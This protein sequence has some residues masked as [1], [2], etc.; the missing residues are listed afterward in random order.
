ML[1]CL[2]TLLASAMSQAGQHALLIGVSDYTDSRIPDLEGPVNDVLALRDVLLKNWQFEDTDITVLL[3]AQAT[4]AAILNAIDALKHTTDKGDDI[5]IYYSGHGTSAADPDLGARLNLPD[6]SGVIVGSDFDPGKLDRMS[7]RQPADDGLLVGRFEIRPRLQALDTNRNVLVI[8]DACFSGNATREV[9]SI[10]KPTRK[11]QIDL[12]DYFQVSSETANSTSRDKINTPQKS[13]SITIDPAV[14]FVYQ[15]TVYFGAA[16]EDQFAVDLSK[17]EID[18]GLVTT[19]DGKPHGGFTDSLLR[20]LSTLPDSSNSLS[21]IQLFNRTLNL[22]NTWCKACGHT[23]VSLPTASTPDNEL[24][25]RTILI[26]SLLLANDT[27]YDSSSE[28]AL[29]E[30]LIIETTLGDGT[31]LALRSLNSKAKNTVA[32]ATTPDVYFTPIKQQI[33][34]YS[35]D[36]QLITQLPI[37]TDEAAMARW[38]AGRQWLKRRMLQDLAKGAGDLQ[39]SFRH[40]LSSNRLGAGE[41]IHF[42]VLSET[43]ASLVAFVL[44]ANSELSLLYPV[45]DT[46]RGTLLP[47]FQ[48]QRIPKQDEP[49]IQVTPPWGTDTV[50]F[51]TL[52]TTHSLENPLR[53]LALL[54]TIP[55]SHRALKAF[56]KALNTTDIRYS[57]ST[58]RI[59]S[60]PNP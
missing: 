2:T 37:D 42:N 3:D 54:E 43:P 31:E 20:A 32:H 23:P 17:A 27:G 51:Y 25:G 18:A 47:A 44:N 57:A 36:G 56:E 6:G 40:P 22:F 38:L 59:V 21:F 46:E 49:T 7:L 41:H 29:Q 50:I 4:E 12:S 24:L 33:N 58:I 10:F 16:A 53:E 19:F 45:N 1:F 26:P 48:S 15:N 14:N 9:V 39:V 28:P 8:F 13:R 30:A 5:I 11:R 35:S 60:S 34:A 55:L 52:P